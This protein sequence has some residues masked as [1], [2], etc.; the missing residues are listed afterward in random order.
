VKTVFAI[1]QI[2]QID[3]NPVQPEKKES[4]IVQM[5]GISIEPNQI[6]TS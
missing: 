1:N 2:N 6:K 3:T 4:A 5:L